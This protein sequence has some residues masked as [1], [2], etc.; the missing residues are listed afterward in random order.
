MGGAAWF[1]KMKQ[2]AESMI[3]LDAYKGP[4]SNSLYEEICRDQGKPIVDTPEHKQ[5]TLK[6]LITNKVLGK[7]HDKVA[8]RRWFSWIGAAFSHLPSWH[9]KLLVIM[10]IG[11]RMKVY[12]TCASLPLV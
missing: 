6:D 12:P 1:E 11:V 4:L 3:N 5:L 2:G 10:H 8:M 9:S 7:K